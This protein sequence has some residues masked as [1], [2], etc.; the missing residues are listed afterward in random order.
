M[1]MAQSKRALSALSEDE[2]R[3]VAVV[4]ITLDPGHDTPEV[5]SR[6]A[7]A[8]GVSA[9]LYHL[10]TGDP[11]DVEHTL[12]ALEIPRTRNEATGVIDHANLFLLVDRAGRIAY[13]LGL[14]PRQERWL[15]SALRVLLHE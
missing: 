1:L 2:R 14:G 12:D 13:R 10:A 9:P 11:E 4:A 8:Q 3:D 7:R 6:M 15:A 5:L